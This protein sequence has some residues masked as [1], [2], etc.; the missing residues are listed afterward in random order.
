MAVDRITAVRQ[1]RSLTKDQ[2]DTLAAWADKGAKPGEP[3]DAPAPR[4]FLEG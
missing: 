3:K 4:Q 2:I 1:R